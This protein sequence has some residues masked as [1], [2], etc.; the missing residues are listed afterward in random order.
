[1]GMTCARSP[2][3]RRGSHGLTV[4]SAPCAASAH[5]GLLRL[6]AAAMGALKD[7]EKVAQKVVASAPGSNW[8]AKATRMAHEM[9]PRNPILAEGRGACLGSAA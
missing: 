4:Q 2:M 9:P 6:T 3:F 8:D 1:M 5:G 7:V